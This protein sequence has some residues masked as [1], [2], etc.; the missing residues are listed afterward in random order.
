MA[1]RPR[2][3]EDPARSGPPQSW[4]R[5]AFRQN[6]DLGQGRTSRSL[7]QRGPWKKSVGVVCWVTAR[8]L[9][10]QRKAFGIQM[11]K[12][13]GAIEEGAGPA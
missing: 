6:T 3:A 10:S 4:S 5:E 13:R 7:R 12:A 2:L 9:T 1:S 11:D 8:Q